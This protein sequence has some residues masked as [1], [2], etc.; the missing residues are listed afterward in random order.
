MIKLKNTLILLTLILSIASTQVFAH[1]V[2]I[3]QP[4]SDA[5]FDGNFEDGSGALIRFVLND[6]ADDISVKVMNGSGTIVRTI[7]ATAYSSGD[8]SIAWDGMDDAGALVTNGD[9]KGSIMTSATTG[10]ADYEVIY[11][12]ET[13]IW[14]RGVTSMISQKVRNFGFQYSASG[15]GYVKGI[16]RH[17]NAGSEWGDIKG[18]VA[19]TVESA[20]AIGPDN[21]RY[22]ATADDDGNVFV[23]RRSGSVPAVY[24]MNVDEQVM[25]RID[26]SDWGGQR[27]QGL[28]V[29]G[30]ASSGYLVVSNNVSDIYGMDLD[31]SANYFDTQSD[32]LVS[33]NP[34]SATTDLFFSEYIEGSGNNKA[35]EIYNG[36]MLQFHLTIIKLLKAIMVKDGSIIILSLLVLL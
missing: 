7:T 5:P 10:Y 19:L 28:A 22:S 3:T 26:S 27:P 1:N 30:G 18:A 17:A 36:T 34:G 20:D 14:T 23:A 29:S 15:G 32:L 25:R 2:R 24:M 9:Y 8:T 12:V 16:A 35:L 21:F 13:G 11:D 4:D 6:A 33:T 31:G